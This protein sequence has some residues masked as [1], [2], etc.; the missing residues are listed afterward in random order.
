MRTER[1]TFTPVHGSELREL[2][3]L[4]R[5][6]LVRQFLFDGQILTDEEVAEVISSSEKDFATAGFG[7]WLLRSAESGPLI[8]TAGLRRLDGGPEIEVVY[9]LDPAYWGQGFAG[10]AAFAVLEYGFGLGL[11]QVLAEVDEGNSGSVAVV[12]R[13]GMR[14]IGTA[15]GV[16]GPMRHY[17][18]ERAEWQARQVKAAMPRTRSK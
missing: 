1:M 11:P 14:R 18:I 16:L 2:C 3:E 17:A 7:I 10:E 4:W 13:L 8:G 12:E 5:K 15:Q 6:P 9:S